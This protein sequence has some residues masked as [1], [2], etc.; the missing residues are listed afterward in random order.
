MKG[1]NRHG[2]SSQGKEWK[3]KETQRNARKGNEMHLER[4]GKTRQEKE[5]KG[6]MRQG[7][8]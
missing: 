6:K 1:K 8:V 4:N 5:R 2:N 3:D 7:M